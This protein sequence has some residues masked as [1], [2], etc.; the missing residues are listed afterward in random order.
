MG[1]NLFSLS[2]WKVSRSV[3]DIILIEHLPLQ[4][5]FITNYQYNYQESEIF[6]RASM[7]LMEC[8]CWKLRSHT[9]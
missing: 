9:K 1:L 8:I 2:E 3:E 7:V 4:K 6:G 5:T